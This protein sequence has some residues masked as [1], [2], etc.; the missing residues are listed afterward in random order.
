MKPVRALLAGAVV[1]GVILLA[2]PADA[3]TK[4]QKATATTTTTRAASLPVVHP[5]AFCSPPGKMGQTTKGTRMKCSKASD[6][7]YRWKKA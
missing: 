2:P 6:G 5:G 3:D 1:A 7:R 4:A